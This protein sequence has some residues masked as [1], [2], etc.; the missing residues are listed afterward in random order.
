MAISNEIRNESNINIWADTDLLGQIG[1]SLGYN[2]EHSQIYCRWLKWPQKPPKY[3]PLFKGDIG[4]VW[5]YKSK[6]V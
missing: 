3:F 2:A 5:R 4:T 6:H 1:A